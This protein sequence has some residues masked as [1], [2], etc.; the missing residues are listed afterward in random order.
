MSEASVHPLDDEG[1][2]VD[3][4]FRIEN[5]NDGFSLFYASR[6][7]TK[8]TPGARN[9]EYHVGLAILLQR[10]KDLDATVTDILLDS[11]ATRER[12]PEERRLS[13]AGGIHY[14]APLATIS[15]PVAFR[16]L[17]SDA[18]KDVL[19][20]PGRNAKHGNRMRSIR[21]SFRLPTQHASIGSERL[22]QQLVS[23]EAV[24][25]TL[26]IV[27]FRVR[28]TRIRKRGPVARPRGNQQPSAVDSTIGRRFNRSPVV[29]AYVLQRA[30]GQCEM[31]GKTTFLTDLADVY[32]E[33]H[34][35]IQLAAGGPD[36][37]ENT[38]AVCANC[39]RELHFGLN[40]AMLTASL[41]ERVP[42]L[43]RRDY[44]HAGT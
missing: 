18:Q 36:T 26:D 24:R 12:P 1:N 38:V 33:I 29:A 44:S 27:E 39:H 35:V 17:I 16:R 25:P 30:N 14:P 22:T 19:T 37:P 31:C 20:A 21:M 10:L 42:E 13:L 5:E 9:I 28:T 43:E 7:G 41:Y 40:R 32:L 3:A 34:H 8:G 2:P 11:A 23:D 4:S 6:G 15:D